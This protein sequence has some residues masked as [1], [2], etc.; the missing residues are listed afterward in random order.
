M[1]DAAEKLLHDG[2]VKVHPPK[3]GEEGLEGVLAGL[4]A[5]K[6]GKASGFKLVH[7]I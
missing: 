2:K 4:E 6:S 1:Y 5:V 7:K 3:V